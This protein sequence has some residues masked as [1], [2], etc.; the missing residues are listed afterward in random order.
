MVV[1]QSV[2]SWNFEGL[3]S[4]FYIDLLNL[5]FLFLFL[6]FILGDMEWLILLLYVFT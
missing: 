3:A 1:I 5:W 4:G 6:V 2:N